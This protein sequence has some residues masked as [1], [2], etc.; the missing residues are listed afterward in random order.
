VMMVL[1]WRIYIFR[2][3]QLTTTAIADSANPVRT[4][5]LT[6]FVHLIIVAGI[7]GTACSSELVIRR[8]F[9][10]TPPSWAAVILAGPALFLAGRALLDYTVFARVDPG[11]LI[12]LV[13]LSGLA[14]AGPRLPPIMLGL[15]VVAVLAAIATAN[16]VLFR[17]RPLGPVAR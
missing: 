10:D 11:R 16:L 17:T 8:P 9:G 13:L 7:V 4:S 3:G 5:Q 6:G 2:A 14:A 12:G 1:I 15:V